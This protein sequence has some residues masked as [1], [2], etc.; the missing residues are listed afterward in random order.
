MQD[1]MAKN[2]QDILQYN[3]LKKFSDIWKLDLPFFEEPNERRGGISHV[4]RMQLKTNAG[5]QKVIFI[6]RQKNH[7]LRNLRHPFRG[8]STFTRELKNIF[9]FQKNNFESIAFMHLFIEIFTFY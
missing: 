7:V 4:V 8:T 1:Y 6:K 9:E 5:E 3:G 2:W